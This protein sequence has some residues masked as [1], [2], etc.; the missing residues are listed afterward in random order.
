[1]AGK[2][3]GSYRKKN[4]NGVRENPFSCVDDVYLTDNKIATVK[5]ECVPSGKGYT[6][7]ER[8]KYYEKN[9]SNMKLLKEAQGSVVRQ[10]TKRGSRLVKI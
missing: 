2:A 4:K 10:K 8:H 1:M 7:E 6:Y 9:P 5:M 3:T